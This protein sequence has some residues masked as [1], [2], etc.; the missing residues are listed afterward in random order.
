MAGK[1]ERDQALPRIL[2]VDDKQQNLV[3]MQTLLKKTRAEV[4]LVDNGNEALSH[5]LRNEYAMSLVDVQM[6]DMNGFELVE[7]MR[8]NPSSLLIPVIFVTAL[9][10]ELQHI[11]HGY[12]VGAVDYLCKPVDTIALL[13]KV[14]F[15]LDIFEAK[16]KL[17]KLL[18]KY[19]LSSDVILGTNYEQIP[20]AYAH[21]QS[22]ETNLSFKQ[23]PNILVVDDKEA[24]IFSIKQILSKLPIHIEEAMSGMEALEK[25]ETTEFAVILLDVQM[26]QMNGFQVAEKIKQSSRAKDTPIIFVTAINKEEEHVFHGYQTGAVDY[27]CKPI[28]PAILLSKVYVFMR[29]Y[30]QRSILRDI[31][32]EKEKLLDEVKEKNEKLGFMAY[33][34]PLTMI[35]NRKA[36]QERLEKTF[37]DAMRYDRKFAVIQVD[38]D[39]FKSIND[40]YGHQVGD[41]VLQEVA[42]RLK[43]SI[44]KNDYVARLGG[45]EFAVILD[46]IPS[47]HSAGILAEKI[48]D[49][50]NESFKISQH[51]V[52]VSLSAGIA[53]YLGES[54]EK[55]KHFDQI[56]ILMRNADSAMYKAKH[57]GRG[58]Y[59]YYTKE[60]NEQHQFKMRIEHALKFALE[61]KEL[62]L[63]YQP[64]FCLRTK[65]ILGAEAL[66][67]WKNA[68]LGLVPP[69]LFIPLAEETQMIIP[70][71]LWVTE[72]AC[73]TLR[74]WIDIGLSDPK[75]AINL[76]PVQL[77]DEKFE[78]HLYRL[79]KELKLDP[80]KI[81]L[82][83]TETAIMGKNKEVFKKL[84]ILNDF[85]ITISIDDFGTGYSMLSYLKIL[86]V[87]ALKID[88][89]FIQNVDK[90]RSDEMIVKSIIDL[91]KNFNLGV[92]AEGVETKKHA[93]FLL[94]QG[95]DVGQ[96]YYFSKP[97]LA[98]EY[99][100][101]AKK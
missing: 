60:F 18:E 92:I 100:I 68:D 49:R 99:E 11:H 43:S 88:M 98:E 79:I 5:M 48:I 58:N 85:G 72:Q 87:D 15:F 21:Y 31:I 73:L 76:S 36:F 61:K 51:E 7:L 37:L 4:D 97:L 33:H 64:K 57:D 16:E 89:E 41:T 86:P 6:P 25:M 69:N 54:V 30:S 42:E 47:I 65:K 62:F 53:C 17:N 23:K 9:N 22:L 81:N 55:N 32:S 66:A 63:M 93:D 10:T 38:V 14:N 34:D 35:P 8:M 82:E 2:V 95:C 1:Q 50:F 56:D 3:A 75:I 78:T 94:S 40:T 70:I 77:V 46:N 91:A 67:R 13:G 52:K 59:Q 74:H 29:L 71:G 39:G 26:P 19:K 84:D 44:R 12:E 28:N 83:L 24:N 20:S 80:Q 45:D 27:L 101:F 90:N 96:G